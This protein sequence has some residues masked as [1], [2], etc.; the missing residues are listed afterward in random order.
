MQVVAIFAE[1]LEEIGV[2][3]SAEE[4]E[5]FGANFRDVDASLRLVV[6]QALG[7]NL[8]V[9]TKISIGGHG[10][11]VGVERI[12]IYRNG[13]R[14]FIARVAVD[15]IEARRET[16]GAKEQLVFEEDVHGGSAR[17]GQSEAAK[18]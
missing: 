17:G 5:E 7:G 1:V 3:I 6:A 9:T 10:G 12:N 11:A 13:R 8:V 14:F 16:E 18:P 2:V 15:A 4:F